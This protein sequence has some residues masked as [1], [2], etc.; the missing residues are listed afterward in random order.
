M[1]CNNYITLPTCYHGQHGA[2]AA[3]AAAARAYKRCC[4]RQQE[5]TSGGGGGGRGGGDGR[6]GTLRSP[7]VPGAGALPA[8]VLAAATG[9]PRDRRRCSSA[10]THRGRTSYARTHD[11]QC[12]TVRATISST[13]VVQHR[14]T[15]NVNVIIMARQQ[16]LTAAMILCCCGGGL[17]V[18][19][20]DL[21][22][23]YGHIHAKRNIGTWIGERGYTI[24]VVSRDD[25]MCG[26]CAPALFFPPP[27]CP[28]S[29]NVENPIRLDDRPRRTFQPIIHTCVYI[30]VRNSNIYGRSCANR[31]GIRLSRT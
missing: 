25:C 4:V 17:I 19:A 15:V 13:I 22:K 18:A 14:L 1:V 28:S 31:R 30:Y 3:A 7:A 6:T 10:H 23:L 12:R 11:A 26:P 27:P 8:W 20:L 29:S 9:G 21:N 2:A 16:L 24:A 5:H